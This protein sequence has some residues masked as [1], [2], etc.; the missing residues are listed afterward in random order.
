[1]VKLLR[2]SSH[3]TDI[4]RLL[5]QSNTVFTSHSRNLGRYKEA[6]YNLHDDER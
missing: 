4:Y 6:S 1:M 3:L 2:M 5:G